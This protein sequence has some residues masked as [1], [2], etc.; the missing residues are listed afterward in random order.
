MAAAQEGL[1][2]WLHSH[3]GHVNRDLDLTAQSQLSSFSEDR[4]IRATADMAEGTRLL[5]V[6]LSLCLHL[7]TVRVRPQVPGRKLPSH[8]GYHVP[9]V[10]SPGLRLRPLCLQQG[11]SQRNIHSLLRKEES[12]PA[13]LATVALL[14]HELAKVL[15]KCKH[16]KGAVMCSTGPA[17]SVQFSVD[18]CFVPAAGSAVSVSTPLAVPSRQSQLHLLVDRSGASMA[19]R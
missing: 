12:L 8:A 3:G 10:G 9:E 13:F 2:K 1:V 15:R 14:L 19:H 6:P 5:E 18:Q 11:E 7:R 16:L 4:G 17:R